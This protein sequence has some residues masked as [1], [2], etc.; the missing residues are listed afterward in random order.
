MEPSP[1][2]DRVTTGIPLAAPEDVKSEEDDDDGEE[3]LV[4]VSSA[5]YCLAH[6]RLTSNAR[7]ILLRRICDL[8]PGHPRIYLQNARSRTSP[9]VTEFMSGF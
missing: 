7:Y 2:G 5:I 9:P 8:H 6:T 1:D 3:T 4:E